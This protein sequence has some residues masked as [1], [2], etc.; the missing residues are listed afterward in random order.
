MHERNE[1]RSGSSRSASQANC[2]AETAVT[3]SSRK[4]TISGNSSR[5]MEAQRGRTMEKQSSRRHR[6]RRH[7]SSEGEHRD[8]PGLSSSSSS[9]QSM[10]SQS[11]LELPSRRANHR[12]KKSL[13]GGNDGTRKSNHS[14]YNPKG[15]KGSSAEEKLLVE[16]FNKRGSVNNVKFTSRR[17]NLGT[18]APPT[19][20]PETP[21]TANK[22]EVSEKNLDKVLMPTTP[23]LAG[24]SPSPDLVRRD[25]SSSSQQSDSSKSLPSGTEKGSNVS[26]RWGEEN[27]NDVSVGQNKRGGKVTQDRKTKDDAIGF[28]NEILNPI[29]VN[30]EEAEEP[31]LTDD[32]ANSNRELKPSSNTSAPAENP[33][34]TYLG[35][36]KPTPQLQELIDVISV[37][38]SEC[39]GTDMNNSGPSSARRETDMNNSGSSIA[40]RVNAC[41]AIKTLASNEANRA[42]LARTKGLVP[43]LA[44]VISDPSSSVE[45]CLR[46]LSALLYLSTPGNNQFLIFHSKGMVQALAAALNCAVIKIRHTA[47]LCLSY[48]VRA[49]ANRKVLMSNEGLLKALNRVI[50]SDRL[51]EKNEEKDDKKS[52]FNNDWGP[53]SGSVD[54]SNG[55]VSTSQSSSSSY[56]DLGA[57]YQAMPMQPEILPGEEKIWNASQLLGLK[58]ILAISKTR[59]LTV[60]LAQQQNITSTLIS[61]SG[62]MEPAANTV[63]LAIFTNLSRNPENDLQLVYHVPGLMTALVS[64]SMSKDPNCRKCALCVLQNL[65]C[66]RACRQELASIPRLLATVT[67]NA[68]DTNYSE[69]QLIAVNTLKNLSDDPS[70]MVNMTNTPGCIETLLA[71]ANG[72]GHEM[73]QYLACDTLATLT[74]WLQTSTTTASKLENQ[75]TVQQKQAMYLPTFKTSTWCQWQ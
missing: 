74:H 18:I 21:K 4:N 25:S 40:R 13:E 51:A 17:N 14:G 35:R 55:D 7:S 30:G 32:V 2:L 23:V 72:R 70:N 41:G 10:S 43:G 37:P 58:V 3:V 39:P 34:G 27:R 29:V 6:T 1:M 61:L 15:K 68:Y 63:C 52:F 22:Y 56:S 67:D 46:S 50:L 31:A 65:A 73:V 38:A 16:K 62:K 19:L 36:I 24:E 47:C 59:D 33:V 8:G 75:G 11:S 5:R 42:S 44:S 60:E 20:S 69:Q 9:M 66:C 45:E 49:E 26:Q 12:K 28:P 53:Q 54:S 64:G 71:L 57:R 48:L